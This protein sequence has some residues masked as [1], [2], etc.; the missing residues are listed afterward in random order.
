MFSHTRMYVY[1][2]MTAN[3]AVSINYKCEDTCLLE[4]EPYRTKI[5]QL[6]VLFTKCSAGY[7]TD[8]EFS[9]QISKSRRISF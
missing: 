7:M 1:D 5:I 4:L 8:A 9:A 2:V 3:T 6:S